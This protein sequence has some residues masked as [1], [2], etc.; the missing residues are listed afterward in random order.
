[1]KLSDIHIR[2][3]FILAEEDIYYLYGTRC[4]EEGTKHCHGLDVYCSTDLENWSEATECFTAPKNFWSHQ[5]FWAPEVHHYKEHYY[6]FVSFIGDTRRRGTQILIADSPMGP[7][8]PHSD[9]PLTPADWECLDGTLY[10][11]DGIPYM[12]FCHEWVQIT[13]GTMCAVQLSDDLKETVGEP[14]VLFHAS[15]PEWATGLITLDD[16]NGFVTDGPF[17]YRTVGGKLLMLW[18]SFGEKGYLEAISYS[19]TDSIH[20]QWKHSNNLLFHQDGGHGMLFRSFEDELMFVLHSPNKPPLE[21]PKLVE[22]IEQD[23]WLYIKE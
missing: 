5:D 23:D 15:Q 17:L 2:D 16:S 8:L 3:P 18:S 7:F 13:D 10:V 14:F 1:M 4:T 20:G 12:V 19:D 11:E 9:G 21:R 6:M 22:L